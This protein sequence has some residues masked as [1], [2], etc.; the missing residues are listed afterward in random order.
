MQQENYYIKNPIVNS[1]MRI[2]SWILLFL[3]A[4][5]MAQAVRIFVNEVNLGQVSIPVV[6]VFLFLTPFMLLA[7]WFAAFGVHK[8]V[9]GQNGGSSLVLAYA[10]LILASVDNLVYIPI[11]YGSDTA[12]SFFILG[13]IELV[14][15][16]LL[17]LYFQ[18]MGAK[19]MALFA[20]VMLVLSF[21]LELI[22]ALRYTSEVGL[23]LYVIYN[24]VKK[25]MN[26]LFAVISIL[27]VAGLEA[28]FIK[29]VK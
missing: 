29:K 21:G 2:L 9:Q 28:N 14:A 6:I 4:F 10:M 26:E 19:V 23:D 11:H 16:V 17:F 20:S 7:A 8:T 27:F 13:G 1:A 3:G 18:G 5:S 25:V 22:D 15:V 24:L 12:T